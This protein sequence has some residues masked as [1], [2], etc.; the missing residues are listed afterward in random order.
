MISVTCCRENIGQKDLLPDLFRRH[1]D[2]I[3][4]RHYPGAGAALFD[5]SLQQ[6]PFQSHSQNQLIIFR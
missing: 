2:G 3:L 5:Q 6:P 4:T 1:T